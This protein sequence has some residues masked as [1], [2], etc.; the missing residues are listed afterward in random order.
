MPAIGHRIL[1]P[2]QNQKI[3]YSKVIKKGRYC[4]RPFDINLN[5]IRYNYAEKLITFL[6]DFLNREMMF[7]FIS[8]ADA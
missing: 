5:L 3:T 7:D 8:N 4:Y 2:Q 6:P 1:T